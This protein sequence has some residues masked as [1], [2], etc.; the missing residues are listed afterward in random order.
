MCKCAPSRVPNAPHPLDVFRPC[1]RPALSMCIG[2]IGQM[3]AKCDAIE[4]EDMAKPVEG[5]KR[6]SIDDLLGN[7]NKL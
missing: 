4:V 1:A 3:H 6:A 7:K 5:R 2:L